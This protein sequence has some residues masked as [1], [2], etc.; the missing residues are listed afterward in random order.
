MGELNAIYYHLCGDTLGSGYMGTEESVFTIIAHIHPELVSVFDL[1]GGGVQPFFEDLRNR[2]DENQV[3]LYVISYN[4]PKQFEALLQSL[5]D[6]DEDILTYCTKFLLNNSDDRSTDEEYNRLAKEYGFSILEKN[7]D[8]LGITGGRQ[9]IAEHYQ[10][11]ECPFMIYFEDDMMMFDKKKLTP[12]D[13]YPRHAVDNSGFTRNV[14]NLF[15]CLL[16][17]MR[18]EK[19]D[20][21]KLNFEEVYAT[22]ST[23]TAWHNVSQPAREK[24]WPDKTSL[25]RT[26]FKEI[27]RF[28]TISY[29]SG[30]VFYCNWPHIMSKEGSNKVFIE[31]EWLAPSEHRIMS[32][33]YE[34]SESGRL[35]S[36]VLLASPV[37]HRRMFDYDRSKR[38]E[39]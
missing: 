36:A 23:Q 28:D 26:E 32:Y 37:E 13:N 33:A 31:R 38:K 16:S 29:A 17:I 24:Y 34:L 14:E 20:F 35:R 18:R 30:K 8:N 7:E 19:Y 21:L 1:G 5:N 39:F 25:P 6:Y 9:F 22:N 3:A 15:H 4:C 12:D 27:G 11:V 2:S 10:N